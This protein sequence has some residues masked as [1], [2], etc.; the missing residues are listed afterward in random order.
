M[1]VASYVA[2]AAAWGV[3]RKWGSQR[4]PESSAEARLF[5]RDFDRAGVP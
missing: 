2:F 1:T 3:E 4:K 5:Q